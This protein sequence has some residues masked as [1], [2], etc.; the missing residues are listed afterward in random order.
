MKCV[1]CGATSWIT[2]YPYGYGCIDNAGCEKRALSRTTYN[3]ALDEVVRILENEAECE[4][5]P[6][7]GLITAIRALKKE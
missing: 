2:K 3:T 7:A 4:C 1:H 6:R 5:C